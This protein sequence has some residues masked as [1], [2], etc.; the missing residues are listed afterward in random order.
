[1]ANTYVAGKGITVTVTVL[2]EMQPP[3]AK[4]D[5]VRLGP[6]AHNVNHAAVG[7]AWNAAAL[8][9]EVTLVLEG[10]VEGVAK[11]SAGWSAGDRLW[12]NG[13]AN[14]L[15][16]IGGA[17]DKSIGIAMEDRVNG[18]ATAS[19]LLWHVFDAE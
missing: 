18:D 17:H 15:I 1:M 3:I 13:T 12:H 9:E 19:V 14:N 10:K 16:D 7:V 11:A 4:G 2:A 5:V 6:L 8:G